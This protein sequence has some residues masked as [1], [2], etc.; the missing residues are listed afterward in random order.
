VLI[1]IIAHLSACFWFAIAAAELPSD[2]HLMD[3]NDPEQPD[4]AYQNWLSG[5]VSKKN[6]ST[7]YQNVNDMDL[8]L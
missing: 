5:T 7:Y 6:A 1:F 2:G 4:P 3:P 8:T